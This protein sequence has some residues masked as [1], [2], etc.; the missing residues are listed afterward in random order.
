[1]LFLIWPMRVFIAHETHS[2]IES[3]LML[4]RTARSAILRDHFNGVHSV[5]VGLW[6][7]DCGRLVLVKKLRDARLN[8]RSFVVAFGGTSITAGHDNYLNQT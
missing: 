1:M 5:A 3:S 2:T 4:V 6:M 8:N 7:N